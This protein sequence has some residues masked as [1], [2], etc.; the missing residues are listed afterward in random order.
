MPRR[1]RVDPFGEIRAVDCRGAL[2]GNRGILHDAAGRILRRHAHRNWVACAVA[3][4]GRKQ[5]VMAPGHYTQLFFLDEATAL[6]AGHRP[7][8]ECRKARYTEF[9]AVWCAVHGRNAD[10]TP[11]PQAIDRALHAARMVRGGAKMTFRAPL[12]GLPDGTMVADG[13]RAVL[14]WQGRHLLWSYAGYREIEP[15]DEREVA[16]LTPAPLVALLAAGWRPE[17]AADQAAAT[18]QGSG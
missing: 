10:G 7:C 13:D 4:K 12:R 1:N 14:I 8:G 3:F 2:M 18:V 9:V 5:E 16:V 6:A 11:V 17:V 15:P